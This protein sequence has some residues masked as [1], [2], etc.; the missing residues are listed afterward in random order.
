M[1]HNKVVYVGQKNDNDKHLQ[2]QDSTRWDPNQ[3]HIKANE[4]ISIELCTK[5]VLVQNWTMIEYKHNKDLL[6]ESFNAT[7]IDVK[8]I[9]F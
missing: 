3:K 1:R 4:I 6:N 7:Y 2:I 9:I 8:N 5:F